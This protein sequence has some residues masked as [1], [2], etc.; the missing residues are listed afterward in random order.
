MANIE[1]FD[2]QK[3]T[4]IEEHN[5]LVNKVNEIVE[6]INDTNL[7]TINSEIAT[8]QSKAAATIPR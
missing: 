7:D 6:V 4:N 8:L 2:Y 5:Q 3:R 1:P